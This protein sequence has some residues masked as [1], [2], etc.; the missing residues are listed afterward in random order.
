MVAEFVPQPGL[1]IWWA[2]GIEKAEGVGGEGGTRN[3]ILLEIVIRD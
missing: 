3:I 2:S 1:Q